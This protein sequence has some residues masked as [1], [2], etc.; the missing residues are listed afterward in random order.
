MQRKA[1]FAGAAA[2]VACVT[3]ATVGSLAQGQEIND[4]NGNSFMDEVGT[5]QK[6]K[7]KSVKLPL[8]YSNVGVAVNGNGHMVPRIITNGNTVV[9]SNGSATTTIQ[10][11]REMPTLN[12]NANVVNGI[13]VVTGG[14][15]TYTPV[16]QSM[17]LPSP[18]VQRPMGNMRVGPMIFGN[19]GA[20]YPNNLFAPSI[21]TVPVGPNS[22]T[23]FSTPFS[24]GSV[25]N[26]TRVFTPST[27]QGI[28]VS[29]P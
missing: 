12:M 26:T 13:P 14:G 4:Q 2:V 22:T 24:S 17:G 9:P 25:T 27:T 29:A 5:P 28:P 6:P 3:F 23:T 15:T 16:G 7:E 11:Y 21:M 10:S 1:E 20:A 8:D 19:G 18:Y